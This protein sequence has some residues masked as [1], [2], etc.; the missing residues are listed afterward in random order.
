MNASFGL[1]ASSVPGVC[2]FVDIPGVS[3]ANGRAVRTAVVSDSSVGLPL[4]PGTQVS[5]CT[6]MAIASDALPDEPVLQTGIVVGA[7]PDEDA[8]EIRD[9]YDQQEDATGP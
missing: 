2:A 9:A 7:D 1:F 4:I 8:T 5:F 3:V 6:G